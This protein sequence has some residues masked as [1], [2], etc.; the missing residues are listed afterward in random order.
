MRVNL[1]PCSAPLGVLLLAA[2][3]GLTG[4]NPKAF[5]AEAAKGSQIVAAALSDPRTFN[6][7]LVQELPN[8]LQFTFEGMIAEDK[9]GNVVPALAESWKFS[10]DNK[11]LVFTL[12]PNLKW[13]DGTPLTADDVVFTFNEVL[14]NK[15]IPNG[16]QDA[17][18]I[19]PKKELP[20][21]RKLGDRQ[22]EFS[23]P[24]PFAPLLRSVGSP[25]L[26]AH[27]LRPAVQAKDSDGKLKFL[28]TWGIDSDPKKVVVNGPY[29]ILSYVPSQRMLFER[30]PHYWKKDD[31]GRQLPY[32]D[33]LVWQIVPSRDTALLQFR[34]GS[35]DVLGIN[36]FHFSLLKQ[37]EQR[38]KFK[39][40]NAGVDSGTGFISFNLN[41]AKRNGKPLVDP[42]RSRWFTNKLFR[43]A[44][45]Y[46]IDR[47][48]MKTNIFRGL[49]ELQDSPISVQSP[50]YLGPKQGLKV[51][52]FNP[53]K[54]KQLLQQA[55]FT[56]GPEGELLDDRGNRVEFTLMTYTGNPRVEAMGSQIKR[57]LSKVGIKVNYALID[58]AT[59]G[60]KLGNTF[61]WECYLG[62]ISGSMDPHSG[63]NVWQPD[64]SFHP[65]NQQPRTELGQAPT[66]GHVVYPWEAK[67]GEL[68]TQGA[69]EM[70]EAKRKQLYDETQRI[71]Q[72][73]LPFIHLVSAYKL[74]AVRDRVKGVESSPLFYEA[75]LWNIPQL[76]IED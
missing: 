63:S 21:V 7:A 49:G 20:K 29:R 62:F 60:E 19:G 15:Q 72:E 35:L 27:I 1:G 22:V 30:N 68:Y 59:L 8:I 38:G 32:I 52:D 54:A 24:Q 9:E 37:E 3:L 44:V 14:L 17:L 25:I 28:S 16:N 56:Y 39:I 61:D 73:E 36:L 76:K 41:Q 6:P 58:F 74:S 34:S 13:S 65:F 45:A 70:N 4:C 46:A 69:Q 2:S 33:R 42:V 67:I 11:R 51:Y 10:P 48:T 18:S 5:R 53:T 47:P 40:Q 26:P 75:E 23:V 71:A 55:G 12:R 50:Y 57:D 66:E 43:Q 64:G 31:Q